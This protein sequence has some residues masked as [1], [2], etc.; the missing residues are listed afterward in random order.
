MH[1]LTRGELLQVLKNGRDA[2]S[3]PKRHTF[4]G[5]VA[6]LENG[7]VFDFGQP[8]AYMVDGDVWELLPFRRTVFR[9]VHELDGQYFEQ[10]L[11]CFKYDNGDYAI[12]YINVKDSDIAGEVYVSQGLVIARYN[13]DPPGKIRYF[14]HENIADEHFSEEVNNLHGLV[15]W[16]CLALRAPEV[17]TDR[18]IDTT[19]E[20]RLEARKR[21]KTL[22]IHYVTV[23]DTSAWEPPP[24]PT[25][26]DEG[27]EK[28]AH[29]SPIAHTRRGHIRHWRGKEIF[30]RATVVNAHKAD[31]TPRGHY[32]V[33]T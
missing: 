11:F 6:C 2:A 16:L 32:V 14:T 18:R 3:G 25:E 12:I 33:K 30:V 31:L 21:G 4:T 15:T 29:A 23:V 24:P 5:A 26:S 28:G 19:R 9:F 1:R 13:Q 20:Q 8:Q 10:F 17:I 7:E 27:R 22:P